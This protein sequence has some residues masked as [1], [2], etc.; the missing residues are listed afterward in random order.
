MA[1][2]PPH[3]VQTMFLTVASASPPLKTNEGLIWP[4][5]APPGNERTLPRV[6]TCGTGRVE[7]AGEVVADVEREVDTDDLTP[8]CELAPQDGSRTP[9]AVKNPAIEDRRHLRVMSVS[10]SWK[11]LMVDPHRSS[12][13]A[14]GD[15]R[16]GR[17]PILSLH[18]FVVPRL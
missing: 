10:L 2:D 5:P 4:K 16:G 15:R 14:V 13:P 12:N 18:A 6:G 17:H 7:V 3:E 1:C 8:P 9:I 11:W